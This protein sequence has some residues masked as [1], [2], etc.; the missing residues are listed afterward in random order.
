MMLFVVANW[1]NYM[2]PATTT[3]SSGE[4]QVD[5]TNVDT[6]MAGWG[7]PAAFRNDAV[8]QVKLLVLAAASG[9]YHAQ[10]FIFD[11]KTGA[12]LSTLLVAT[13]RPS[14]SNPNSSTAISYV[15]IN[16]N[17]VIKQQYTYYNV[18]RCHRCGRC[19]W[20][21]HCCCHTYRASSPRGDTP[22]ELLIIEHKIKFDQ[23]AWFNRQTLS[24]EVLVDRTL[25]NGDANHFTAPLTE[26]IENFL[27]NHIVK[28]QV[29]TPYND[30]V[31][32]ALQS[33]IGSL[34]LASQSLKMT[35]VASENIPE[36]LS[37]LAK[38]YGFE[39]IHETETFLQQLKEGRFSYE[40]FFTTST[41]DHNKRITMKYVWIIGQTVNN[42]TYSMRFLVLN[43]TSQ[44]LI[45]TLLSND[46]ITDESDYQ[47]K[48]LNIAR[49][50]TLNDRGE[51]LHEDLLT[52]I[53]P[54]KL[55]ITKIALN[56]LRFIAA[57]TLVPQK[58]RM[59]SYFNPEIISP[60]LNHSSIHV[61]E[62]RMISADI[63]ALS[64]A[65]S[66]AAKGWKDVVSAFKTS[67]S[68]SITRIVRFGFDHFSQKS[69]VLKA[70][71]IPASRTPEF[72]N[73]VIYD[74]N[75]PPNGSFM[76]AVTYSDDFAWEKIDY[77]YSPSMNGKYRALTLFKNGD[78]VSNTASFFIINVDADWQMAPDLLLIQ[79]SRS[80]LGGLFQSSK[81][82]IREVP[83]VLS[84]DE[85]IKLQRF[86]M[87]VAMDNLASTLGVNVTLPSLN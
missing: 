48:R 79:K 52:S 47:S 31:L 38:Q 29:L 67:S 18:R 28:T 58:H 35:G 68:T 49:L 23:F 25:S 27:S 8:K 2:Q 3:G 62:S 33:N 36:I 16:S 60:Q 14:S 21:G 87:L 40:N 73:A 74:Y 7:I 59:L 20:T 32:S 71:N 84:M 50:S 55:K 17:A 77:F 57:S 22:Q 6:I 66:A 69:T 30:S 4:S 51:F 85:V 75:L 53:T 63:I 24:K 76:L 11:T 86:F 39:D 15:I 61:P 43:I 1:A 9:V 46:T 34:K 80:I 81:Q 13:K 44:A 70:V 12:S 41:N 65:V 72:I 64:K 26:A 42:L 54:W 10:A 37:F 82:S 56:I 45:D 19:L 83:H 5:A 78:S